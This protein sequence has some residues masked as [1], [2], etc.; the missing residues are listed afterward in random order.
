MK[1]E[2]DEHQLNYLLVAN[3]IDETDEA[4]AK[5]KFSNLDKVVFISA[6]ENLHTEVLKERMVDTVLQGK[7]Q[8]RKYH[9]Y[10]CKTLS[11]H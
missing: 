3:K 11:M 7:V 4:E 5:E 9:H 6:K 1:S 10:Q 2:M 8:S